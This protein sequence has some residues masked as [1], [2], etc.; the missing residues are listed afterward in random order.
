MRFGIRRVN[1]RP[2]ILDIIVPELNGV[3]AVSIHNINLKITITMGFKRKNVEAPS[4]VVGVTK[5]GEATR[6][7]TS[8]I[9]PRVC[10]FCF[11]FCFLRV[12]KV[13]GHEW[14]G[15]IM[16]KIIESFRIVPE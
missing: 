1:G 3:A 7:K 12:T 9:D 10:G 6:N 11:I 14:F 13:N 5:T 8:A 4:R 15:Y 16:Q 2:K